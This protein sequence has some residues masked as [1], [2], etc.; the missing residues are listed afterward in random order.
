M[1]EYLIKVPS[2]HLGLSSL[3]SALGPGDRAGQIRL[4][5]LYPKRRPRSTSVS[6]WGACPPRGPREG[7][8]RSG[9]WLPAH[10]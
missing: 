8:P 1:N 5:A 10:S 2:F 6:D 3:L 4:L 9:Q 7:T